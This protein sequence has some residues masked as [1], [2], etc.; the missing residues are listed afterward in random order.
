M[1]GAAAASAASA[2]Y[3]E[4]SISFA[5]E[6]IQSTLN[7][8]HSDHEDAWSVFTAIVP[9]ALVEEHK[10][11]FSTSDYDALQSILAQR[12]EALQSN[13]TQFEDS[14]VK[15]NVS[16]RAEAA[17]GISKITD[18]PQSF[19]SVPLEVFLPLVVVGLIVVNLDYERVAKRTEGGKEISEKL[20]VKISTAQLSKWVGTLATKA[21]SNPA[22]QGLLAQL[23]DTAA[24]LRR[25]DMAIRGSDPSDGA[26]SDE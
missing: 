23:Q 20:K 5:R 3:V 26:G 11:D 12:F 6:V 24:R 4:A 13:A 15:K 18:S 8:S 10:G 17:V 25:N 16:E 1:G 21:L 19:G 7:E 2:D 14:D 9:E 22:V